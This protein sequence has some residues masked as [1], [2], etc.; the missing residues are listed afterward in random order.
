MEIGG[1]CNSNV[2]CGEE[3]FCDKGSC[4]RRGDVG[5]SCHSHWNGCRDGLICAGYEPANHNEH[6]P[7]RGNP[8]T[9][10][11][12][13]KRG[14]PCGGRH[15]KESCRSD[16]FCDYSMTAPVCREPLPAGSPCSW[17]NACAEGL[18]CAGIRLGEGPSVNRSRMLP[19][20]RA[21]T[22]TPFGDVGIACDPEAMVTAC[23]GSLRCDPQTRT[24][25]PR[26]GV[27]DRCDQEALRCPYG[28]YC[29][30]RTH[31]CAPQAAIG[32]R[33][34][35]KAAGLVDREGPC[36]LGTCDRKRR[37]CRGLCTTKRP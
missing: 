9:C 33:C 29:D 27:G 8:G 6:W 35:P 12:P 7:S 18:A 24:C 19:V 25:T 28:D 13:R 4:R 11:E 31:T 14:E 36:F 3:L 16:L 30:R 26:P 21:G 23:S 32:E 37:S 22:C 10:A 20:D 2:L 34:D 5:E 15:N 17:L 1:A